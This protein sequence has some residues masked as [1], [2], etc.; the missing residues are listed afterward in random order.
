[1]I[2]LLSI[3]QYL[4]ENQSVGDCQTDHNL[5]LSYL[6]KTLTQEA[7]QGFEIWA[8]F[9]EQQ[10]NFCI[11]DDHQNGAEYVDLLLNPEKFTGYRG[12]S[13]HRIWRSIYLEN[14][15]DQGTKNA[16]L[17]HIKQVPT[18]M[19]NL[20]MEQRAFYRLLS[21]VHSSINIHLCA[22]HLL[23]EGNSFMATA[24]THGVWGRNI[25]EFMR[26]F[27]PEETRSQGPNWLK[28]LY[29]VYLLELR[30]LA[31]A[32]PYLRKER[33]FT[34]NDEEDVSVRTAVKD[35]LNIIEL[36]FWKLFNCGFKL[37]LIILFVLEHSHLISM[38]VL[39]L[40]DLMRPN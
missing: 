9:D 35:I 37:I 24:D 6:N 31:K 28:N 33:F 15:F 10:D 11:L 5:E 40:L 21:G 20:C 26:R 2:D 19:N 22:Y 1:M 39:C 16:L 36:V 4:P 34:G 18:P 13:A 7:M 3:L 12:E 25:E 17:S 30:A 8:D 32:A 23:S 29:F 14:C 27:S 38:K